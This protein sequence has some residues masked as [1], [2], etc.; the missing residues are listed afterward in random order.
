MELFNEPIIQQKVLSDIIKNDNII[1]NS[2]MVGGS[3]SGGKINIGSG[4]NMFTANKD[5]IFLGSSSFETAPFSVDMQ[6]NLYAGSATIAGDI[7]SSNYSG[8]AP[9]TGYKLEY[10]TG[11][12]YF[13]GAIISGSSII[14][15]AGI[16]A[17]TIGS[18][19]NSSGNFI[20]H[21]INSRINTSTG[22]I[23][24][25][26]DVNATTQSNVGFRA[27]NISW[28]ASGDLVSGEGVAMTP[29]GLLGAKIIGG[30]STATFS[31]D[32]NG[33]AIFRGE[34]IG[35]TITGGIIKTA[36]SGQRVEIS[37][38]GTY[39]N[40][41]AIFDSTGVL[42]LH[43]F[44]DIISSIGNDTDIR[45]ENEN[46]KVYFPVPSAA[47]SYFNISKISTLE[48][49][50]GGYPELTVSGYSKNHWRPWTTNLDL[51]GASYRWRDLY[52]NG[53]IYLYGSSSGVVTLKPSSTAG[54][55]TF[56][57]PT[58][59]GSSGQVLATNG[60][61]TTSW[62]TPSSFSGNLSDLYINTVKNW[63][64]YGISNLGNLIGSTSSSVN[65][66]SSASNSWWNSL[67][68][69]YIYGPTGSNPINIKNNAWTQSLIPDAANSFYC[70]LTSY[71]WYQVSTRIITGNNTSQR[72]DFISTANKI[73]YHATSAHDFYQ[74]GN[75]KAI[76]DN[77]IWTAGNL[78]ADGTKPF[79]IKHPD[80][81]DRLLRYT[82]QESP[83]VILR[84]RGKA[85]TSSLKECEVLTPKHF[86]MITEPKE[87][88]TVNITPIGDNHI[89]IEGTPNNKGF[90][91]KSDNENVE[92]FYEIIAIRKGYAN[93][94][95]E[96]DKNS[97]GK[98]RELFNILKK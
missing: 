73:Q 4:E 77:N 78:M 63:G 28:N 59:T 29:K 17:N 56:T 22:A 92:F 53:S 98:D 61:G 80:G 74:N 41:I 90:K 34:V 3:F 24:G 38:S 49:N 69:Q 20:N 68:V 36:I 76:I 48:V 50:I 23:L 70:G 81:S 18:A 83:E 25:T 32:T 14:G 8:T 89:Y 13:G 71:Y 44:D 42:G 27:G 9:Y 94:A 86:E 26:F 33:N 40:S 91:V 1:T 37:T 65:L 31:I 97:K 88:V 79:V 66:G 30:T 10:S 64:G 95:I 45:F 19:I 67:Y 2:T 54:T 57:L 15:T 62:I 43:L 35:A 52:L 85:K 60:S 46:M 58:G 5:G 51:G 82:A 93:S 12:A 55:W 39:Q 87:L 75:I 7:V 16:L 72:I 21:L 6:G 11:N 96:I 84:D 47:Q